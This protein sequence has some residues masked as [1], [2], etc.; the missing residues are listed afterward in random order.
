MTQKNKDVVVTDTNNSEDVSFKQAFWDNVKTVFLAVIIA[1][2]IRSLF[3]EPFR[4]PSGSMYPTLRVGDYLFV[5][6]YS[7]GYSRYSFPFGLPL[8]KGRVWYDVPQRGDV[9]VFKF[10]KNTNTDFIKRVIGL[11]GDKV[12]VKNGRLYINDEKISRKDTDRYVIDEYVTMPEFYYQYEE[13]LPN[14][15]VHNILELSD[16]E[17][18]VDNTDEFVVPDDHYFVMGDNRD[19]SDDSR[20]SVGFVPKDNLV[21]KAKFIF[22]SHNDKGTIYKP[23]TWGKAIRWDRL[24]KGIR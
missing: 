20:I 11:P 5:S 10:P 24:F 1:V 19:R 16:N 13:T 2:F 12:Q 23:W 18:I 6:K 15:F 8:F 14:G 3:F 4:I 21:G 17:R 22:F 7:Y 9:V